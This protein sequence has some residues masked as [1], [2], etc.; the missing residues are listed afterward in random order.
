MTKFILVGGYP[1]KATDGGRAF[2]DEVL[3]GFKKPL[4]LLDCLFARPQDNWEKAFLQDKEFFTSNI[5]G[6]VEIKLANPVTFDEQVRWADAIYMR[7][8]IT[9]DLIDTLHGYPNLKNELD[10][11]TLA[12]SSAGADAIATHHYNLDLQSVGSGLGLLPIK[13]IPH[14]RS[15]YAGGKIDWDKA[16]A[17]L[18]AY[19][20]DLPILTLAE[21][22]FEVRTV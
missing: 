21:G 1:H 5:I 4:R 9:N 13:M 17:E 15:D 6:E 2:C 3:K 12:G 18:K 22:Q 11:K 10:G 7:G 8:G 14:W 19:G 16:Y 20:D